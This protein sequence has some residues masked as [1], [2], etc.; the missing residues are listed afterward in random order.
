MSDMDMLVLT[1]HSS[2]STSER[3]YIK[4][5]VI[6]LLEASYGLVIG[7]VQIEGQI[8]KDDSRPADAASVANQCGYC[9]KDACESYSYLSCLMCRNFIATRAQLPFFNSEIARIEAKIQNATT[10]HDIEDLRNIQRLLLAY[11]AQL[12]QEEDIHVLNS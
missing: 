1:G 10:P 6:S 2:T 8:S 5:D 9:G 12:L 11:L 7:D 3:H 4:T